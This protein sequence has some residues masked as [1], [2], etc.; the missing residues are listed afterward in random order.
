LLVVDV[1]RIKLNFFG[2]ANRD[3]GQVADV[4]DNV[5]GTLPHHRVL[6]HRNEI[7]GPFMHI[8][9]DVHVLVTVSLV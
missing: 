9:L 5:D 1:Q 2:T 3:I 6:E 7:L 8:V 4:A